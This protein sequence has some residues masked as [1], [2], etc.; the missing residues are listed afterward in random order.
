MKRTDAPPFWCTSDLAKRAWAIGV[1]FA[2]P[3]ANAVDRDARF[4]LEAANEMRSQ[5]LLGAMIPTEFGGEGA[6]LSEVA[7]AVRAIASHCAAS[8]LVMAMHQEQTYHMIGHGTTPGLR[9][10][11]RQVAD[12]SVLIANANSEVG[13]GGEV[14]RSICAVEPADGRFHIEKKV[15]AISY[16]LDADAIMLNARRHPDAEPNDQVFL[17]LGPGNF[18]VVPTSEWNTTGLRGTCSYSFDLVGEDNEDMILPGSWPTIA[19]QTVGAS[20]ILINSVW[21]GIAEAAARKA[22]AYIRAE[23]RKKIGTTPATASL[24][25]QLAVTLDEARGMMAN[26]I[27]RYE[28]VEGTDGVEDPRLMM[29]MR[30]LKLSVSMLALR[31]V[32]ES[33]LICGLTGYKH[34]SPYCMDRHIRDIHGAPIMQHN[35]R[36]LEYNTRALMM[37]KEM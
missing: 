17:T 16:G 6:P 34:D 22:H 31:I 7:G 35:V 33:S 19:S 2:G 27:A 32:S 9:D 4:P 1:E 23:A 20:V 36:F 28:A 8:G 3:N 15:L 11:L 14:N 37:T 24:L 26:A 5:G 12:G 10:L 30:N 29:L 18:K 21:L 13:L 25:G